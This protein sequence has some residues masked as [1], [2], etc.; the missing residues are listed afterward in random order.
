ME[1][2]IHQHIH[3]SNREF[4]P[5]REIAK[6]LL[7]LEAIIKQSPSVLESLFPGTQIESVE[8]FINELKYGSI[9]QDIVI[10]FVFGSQKKID[11][12]IMS[13]REKAGMDNINNNHRLYSA[14]LVM[15]LTSV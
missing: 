4:V 10:K 12:F 11:Q 5:L 7:A 9:W 8:V 1:I 15:T 13:L 3:Y 6:G 2:E 14:I